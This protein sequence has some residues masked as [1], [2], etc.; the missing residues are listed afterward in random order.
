M[1]AAGPVDAPRPR[2]H[3]PLEIAARFPQRPQR[4][5]LQGRRTT[6]NPLVAA[7]DSSDTDHPTWVAGFQ[8]FLSGRF[9]TF[10]DTRVIARRLSGPPTSTI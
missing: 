1:D 5:L 3:S 9:S 2:A 10:G 4:L 8:T 6:K 7:D